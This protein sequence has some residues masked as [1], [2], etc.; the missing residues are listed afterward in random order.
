LIAP[1][2]QPFVSL[3]E[4]FWPGAT[5]EL[6]GARTPI[7]LA[8]AQPEFRDKMRS[9][10][11]IIQQSPRNPIMSTLSNRAPVRVLI[12]DEHA[13][14]RAA[15][16]RLLELEPGFQVAGETGGNG[17]VV[18][19]ARRLQPDVLLMDIDTPGH[20]TLDAVRELNRVAH[21]CR[22]IILTAQIHQ[23]QLVRA[24]R[25]GARGVMTKASPVDL[26]F[27][28]IDAVM[29]GEYWVGRDRVADLV[30][31]FRSEPSAQKEPPRPFGLTSRELQIVQ[32]VVAGY[33]NKEIS[34]RLSISQNTTKHHLS[35]IFDKLGVSNRLELA[36][37]THSHRILEDRQV[38]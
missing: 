1:V 6:N 2:R 32:A 37:F 31:V 10:F 15:L 17:E 18:S 11:T 36:L 5:R 21:T 24:F 8:H 14:F 26:L 34:R 9:V 28:S 30:L 13:I 29:A 19:L 25:A 7:F 38:P 4:D 20:C 33:S 3:C 22:T 35:S 23:E 12:A 27:K 16:R